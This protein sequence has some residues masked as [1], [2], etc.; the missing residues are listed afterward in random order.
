MQ[1]TIVF[2]IDGIIAH[3]TKEQVY[4]NE[5]GWAFEK[6]HL[7]PGVLKVINHFRLKGYRIVLNTSRWKQDLKKTTA[8]LQNNEVYFDEL[9][10]EKPFSMMYVDDKAYR[11]RGEWSEKDILEME[12][13]LEQE[14]E[15][16]EMIKEV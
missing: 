5:A 12:N 16:V 11:H 8:W 4:S 14:E 1:K 6:C 13:L 7:V 3:G 2:D 10:M 15:P 9:H